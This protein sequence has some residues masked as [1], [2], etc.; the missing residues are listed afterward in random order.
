MTY[1][2]VIAPSALKLL[3]GISDRRIREIIRNRIDGLKNEPEKQGKALTGE[4]TGFRTLRAVGQR[5]RI[6]YRVER[7]KILV[8]VIAIGIR[9]EGSKADIYSL[10]RKLLRLHLLDPPGK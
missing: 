2:I 4:L 9:K 8:I 5:Y 6:L 10:A 3:R 7:N 1:K